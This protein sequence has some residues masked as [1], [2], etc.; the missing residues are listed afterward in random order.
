MDAEQKKSIFKRDTKE[1]CMCTAI[2]FTP[3]SSSTRTETKE[4]ST[5]FGLRCC[6]NSQD[7]MT[8]PTLIT[9]AF[10]QTP[11]TNNVVNNEQRVKRTAVQIS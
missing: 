4:K 1:G 11:E 2:K 5:D 3:G 6:R 9:R 8:L 10:V 7:I